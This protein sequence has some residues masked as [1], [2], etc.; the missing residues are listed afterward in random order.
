MVTFALLWAREHGPP[1]NI[2]PEGRVTIQQ[3]AGSWVDLVSGPVSPC[4][5]AVGLEHVGFVAVLAR[6]WVEMS[7]QHSNNQYSY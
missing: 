2:Q 6:H 1:L 4:E 7:A 3:R 5:L